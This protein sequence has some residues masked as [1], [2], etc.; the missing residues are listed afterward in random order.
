MAAR[1]FGQ[2]PADWLGMPDTKAAYCWTVW[3]LRLMRAEN[4]ARKQAG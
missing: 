2:H 1:E 3:A 4:E